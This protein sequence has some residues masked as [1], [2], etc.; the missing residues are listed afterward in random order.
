[1][2]PPVQSPEHG[3]TTVDLAK[4][5]SLAQRAASSQVQARSHDVLL[6]SS[7]SSAAPVQ[8]LHAGRQHHRL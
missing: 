1:M 7:L 8:L 4:R 6:P 3:T 2:L 5:T